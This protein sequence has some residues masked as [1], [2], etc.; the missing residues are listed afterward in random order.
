MA[1]TGQELA[2]W[3][4]LTNKLVK[5]G[6]LGTLDAGMQEIKEKGRINHKA[7]NPIVLN[8]GDPFP[9]LECEACGK[10]HKY[11]QI[12]GWDC[13]VLVDESIIPNSILGAWC[14]E[15]CLKESVRFLFR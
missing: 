10:E 15:K 2:L 12:G 5:D 11:D 8:A 9:D 7:A 13:V 6:Q 3:V 1:S 4:K 14:D